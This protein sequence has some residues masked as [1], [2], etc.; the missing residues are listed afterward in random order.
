MRIVQQ[1]YWYG[2]YR[3]QVMT[4]G[5]ARSAFARELVRQVIQGQPVGISDAIVPVQKQWARSSGTVTFR[6]G[7]AG[8]HNRRSPERTVSI[9]TLA[10]RSSRSAREGE[11]LHRLCHFW[12]PGQ[13]LELG[14]HLGISALYQMSA[15]PTGRF[16]TIEGA[17]ELAAIARQSWT[18]CSLTVEPELLEGWFDDV[19]PSL[20]EDGFR[21]DYALVD[22]NHR[23]DATLRYVRWLMDASPDR[24]MI[25]LD[26][27]YWSADMKQAWEDILCWPEIGLSIDLFQFGVLLLMSDTKREHLVCRWT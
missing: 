21:P 9:R 20:L 18:R 25:V 24:S 13:C 12:Q 14:T 22:G 16:V 11:L 2:R 8:S 5:G 27:I 1:A 19:L 3:W 15:V 26:D 7:G 6:D 17:P 10:L 4:Q 23:Y